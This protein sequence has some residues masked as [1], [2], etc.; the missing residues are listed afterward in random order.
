MLQI[1]TLFI[2]L[3]VKNSSK[4]N[5]VGLECGSTFIGYSYN[6]GKNLNCN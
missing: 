5:K 6:F 1:A 3:E 2:D 4:S